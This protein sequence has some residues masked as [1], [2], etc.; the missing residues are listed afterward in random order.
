MQ[1]KNKND[2]PENII[3]NEKINFP[4]D[5][6]LKVILDATI[7]D[8]E[9][10]ANITKILAELY[11]PHFKWK[12]KFSEKARFISITIRVHLSS[13]EQMQSLYSKLREVPGMKYAL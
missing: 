12:M 4:V 2:H 11:I 1:N 13:H 3:R 9:H 8:E 10:K 5:F 7:S 6:D